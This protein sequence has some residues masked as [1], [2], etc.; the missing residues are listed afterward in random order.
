MQDELK[1][2]VRGSVTING[3]TEEL[4]R[5]RVN[6]GSPSYSTIAQEI[7][8]RREDSGLSPAQARIAR[9]TIYDLFR[10]GRRRLD[11]ALVGEVLAALGLTQDSIKAWTT[12]ARRATPDDIGATPIDP[13]TGVE[14]PT[15]TPAA[16]VS[17][18]S[19]DSTPS[20]RPWK[21]MAMILFACLGINLLGRGTVVLL[22]L[23]LHLDMTGTAISAILL[24]PWWGA[25]TGVATNGAG[26]ALSGD[27]SFPFAL[28]NVTGALVWGYGVRRFQMGRTIPRYFSLNLICA[29]ACSVVAAPIV[30]ILGDHLRHA[31]DSVTEHLVAVIHVVAVSIFVSNLATSLADKTISGFIA[32]VVI[33]SRRSPV[34][35]VARATEVSPFGLAAAQ[36]ESGADPGWRQSWPTSLL[37]HRLR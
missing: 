14:P 4:C 15:T 18:V 7:A 22:D 33:E 28:V 16:Q 25:L 24:G 26:A 27:T 35:V 2:P 6:A 11:V 21:R 1:A 36:P 9:S 3:F 37:G 10:P 34:S 13:I 29:L 31:S 17:A 30:Y 8:A 32:L 20:R 5:L 12:V 19:A 23:P